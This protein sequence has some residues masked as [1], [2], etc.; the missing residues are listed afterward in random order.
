LASEDIFASSQLEKLLASRTSG[1]RLK[2]KL[3]SFFLVR[4]NFQLGNHPDLEVG[5]VRWL[6]DLPTRKERRTAGRP[7]LGKALAQYIKEQL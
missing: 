3:R 4:H 5:L 6:C 7:K 1:D 2:R